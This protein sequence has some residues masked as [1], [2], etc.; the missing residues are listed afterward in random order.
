MEGY[1]RGKKEDSM[2]SQEEE[3]DYRGKGT[4]SPHWMPAIM[5]WVSMER[6]QEK[7]RELYQL[8]K[9]KE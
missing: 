5:G 6:I 2:P 1:P 4:D 9:D 7:A 8:F 3:K